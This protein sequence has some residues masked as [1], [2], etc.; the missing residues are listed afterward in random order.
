LRTTEIQTRTADLVEHEHAGDE[1]A[2]RAEVLQ[3]VVVRR[4]LAAEDGAGGHHLLLDERV[5]HLRAHRHAAVL[6]HDLGH[7]T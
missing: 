2:V 6:A 5:A 3:E 1:A 4:V 7:G